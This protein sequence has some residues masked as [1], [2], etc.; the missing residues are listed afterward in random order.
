MKLQKTPMILLFAAAVMGGGVYWLESRK[1]GDTGPKVVGAPGAVPLF[2]GVREADIQAMTVGREG[3]ETIALTFE[4][5]V[6]PAVN[7][8]P[9]APTAA[10]WLVAI[11][12][13]KE[14]ASLAEVAYLGNLLAT[15]R[16][17]KEFGVGRDR[18]GEF[19]LD[20]PMAR[21]EFR[22]KEGKTHR[23]LLGK[24]TFNR[25]HL[26]GLIDPGDKG[27]LVVS[28]V[29]IELEGAVTRRVEEWRRV[30]PSPSVAPSAS[31]SVS[32]SPIV[33][34]SAKN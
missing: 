29:P 27:D 15:G 28:L 26:Y 18:L 30:K 24:A 14:S 31:P 5:L 17:E 20:Q 4:S 25:S 6:G 23:L 21:V 34:P 11:K 1:A 2:A 22:L 12:N 32:P 7:G 8:K 9:A 13:S 3:G 16:R 10:Q 19:G 33:S